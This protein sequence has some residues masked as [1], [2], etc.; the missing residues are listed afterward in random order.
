MLTKSLKHS[1]FKKLRSML[2]LCSLKEIVHEEK[3]EDSYK[4]NYAEV[5]CLGKG[6]LTNA[7]KVGYVVVKVDA[8]TESPK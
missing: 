5:G 4:L 2:R 1:V 6:R 3:V 8:V 7:R